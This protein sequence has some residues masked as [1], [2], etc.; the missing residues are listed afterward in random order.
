MRHTMTL[1][2][3]RLP[4]SIDLTLY[5]IR[6]DLKSQKLFSIIDQLNMGD[7]PYQPHLAKPILSQLNLDDGSDEI[8][9]FYY[10]LIEKHARKL[11]G[12]QKSLMKQTMKVY[13]A[14]MG[15][16]ERRKGKVS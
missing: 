7:C 14:L 5:L 4:K 1:P 12:D 2:F 11:H 15:E 13:L 9:Q 16:K 6:E 3:V 10:R 8:F